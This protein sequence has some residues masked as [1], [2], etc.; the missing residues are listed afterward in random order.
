MDIRGRNQRVYFWILRKIKKFRKII[1]V[2][3]KVKFREKIQNFKVK[4]KKNYEKISEKF[5]KKSVKIILQNFKH[6]F[7][8]KKLL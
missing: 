6:L 3:Q 4:I 8:K 5:Q 1:D 7:R 2:Q